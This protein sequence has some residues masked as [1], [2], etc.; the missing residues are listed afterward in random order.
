M[1]KS[2]DT[3]IKDVQKEWYLKNRFTAKYRIRHQK[4]KQA[5][6]ERNLNKYLWDIAKARA[7]K[8]GIVFA[9]NPEDII[10]PTICP[11]F[12]TPFEYGTDY[13]ASLDR[14]DPSKGYIKDN[15]QVLSLKANAMKRNASEEDLRKFAQWALSQYQL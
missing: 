5:W 14:V 8:F 1:A 9:I 3:L 10:I 12:N 11:V 4:Q 6:R 2:I 15:I 13:A 7:K